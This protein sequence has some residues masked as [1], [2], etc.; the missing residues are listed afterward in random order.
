MKQNYLTPVTES[1]TI[2]LENNFLGGSSWY[3]QG[4]QGNFNYEV[5]EDDEFAN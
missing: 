3:T 1:V 2:D 4:G 5:E